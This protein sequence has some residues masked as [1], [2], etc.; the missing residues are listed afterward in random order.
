MSYVIVRFEYP[1]LRAMSL[2]V[3]NGEQAGPNACREPYRYTIDDFLSACAMA[4]SAGRSYAAYAAYAVFNVAGLPYTFRG[5]LIPDQLQPLSP[6]CALAP[7]YLAAPHGVLLRERYGDRWLHLP[8]SV[9]GVGPVAVAPSAAP[10]SPAP[11]PAASC[12]Y[13]VRAGLVGTD[14]DAWSA[15]MDFDNGRDAGQ[16]VGANKAQFADAGKAL[17]IVKVEPSETVSNW[18]ER[19]AMRLTDGTYTPLPNGWGDMIADYYPDHFAHVAQS[20][21][22]K[23]AFTESE[24]SGERDKQKVLS[25]SAYVE[26]F[27]NGDIYWHSDKRARFVA[28]LI[29]DSIKPLFAPLGDADAMEAIYRE[30]E[31]T[32]ARGCMSH[33]LH[34]YSS[35]FHPVRV[36]AMGGD[37]TVA[38]LRG[39]PEGED[40]SGINPE[41]VWDGDGEVIARCL[42][43]PEAKEFGRV[44]GFPEHQRILRTALEAQGYRAGDLLGAKIAKVGHGS[45]YIMPYLD[46]GEQRVT[47]CGEYF[48]TGGD[49]EA[50][51]TDGLIFLETLVSCDRCG[52][53]V[54]EDETVTV[55]T[56]RYDAETWCE[57]CRDNDASYSEVE[58]AYI[59]DCEIVSVRHSGSRWPETASQWWA[60]DSGYIYVDTEGAYVEDAFVCDEC[61]ESFLDDEINTHGH[62]TVC[63][64]CLSELEAAEA[65]ET[66]AAEA[67]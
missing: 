14:R 36:Y 6:L 45:G 29:G 56:G 20:D 53:D 44:Y 58:D 49:Y 41:A 24:S 65:E 57:C 21:K 38:F 51:R 27:F 30:T 35:P 10:V 42:V 22:R 50:T 25:A 2:Y 63:S 54:C 67:A 7:M 62:N 64:S 46:I 47:D 52:D 31:D 48:H 3:V 39:Y 43:W 1:S 17:V 11:A 16:W 15:V 32:A 34:H 66:E 59:H 28:D 18:R 33:S 13:E 55:H 19:E 12:R 8:F 9:D 37:I 26:R 60:E 5:D 23:V 61:R 40:D 4:D